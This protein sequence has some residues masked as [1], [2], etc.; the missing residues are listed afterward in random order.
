MML[1]SI[2]HSATII[3]PRGLA[4]AKTDAVWIEINPETLPKD[5]AEA[6]AQYKEMYKEM[7]A[8]RI[9]FETML[10]DLTD[11]PK[12]KRIVFGYNFGKLSVAIVD[13]DRKPARA[14][15]ARQ[16]LADFIATQMAKGHKV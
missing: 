2:G 4:M 13:D 7:K 15:P 11:A 3:T 1:A 12:G 5:I 9:Q 16:S 14:T 8:Q 10:A 6:Y